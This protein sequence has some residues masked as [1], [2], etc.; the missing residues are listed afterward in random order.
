MRRN[1]VKNSNVDENIRVNEVWEYF[2][3]LYVFFKI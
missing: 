1:L 3:F 2:E